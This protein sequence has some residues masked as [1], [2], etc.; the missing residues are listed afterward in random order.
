M[1]H[2]REDFTTDFT[3]FTDFTDVGR[4]GPGRAFPV[5]ECFIREIRAIRGPISLLAAGCAAPFAPFCGK[6]SQVPFHQ[7]LTVK[8]APCQSSPIK[9]NQVI[10]SVHSIEHIPPNPGPGRRWRA[11]LPTKAPASRTATFAG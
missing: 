10:F 1:L 6:S 9:S 4:D 7:Q 11:A 8:E 2:F 3:D 5:C